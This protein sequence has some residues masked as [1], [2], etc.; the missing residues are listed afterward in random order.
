MLSVLLVCH[1]FGFPQ[2]Y[3]ESLQPERFAYYISYLKLRQDEQKK[4]QKKPT[5]RKGK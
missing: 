3:V 2:E 4:A 1:E 5:P